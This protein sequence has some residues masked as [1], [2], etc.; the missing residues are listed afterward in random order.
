MLEL[1]AFA[2]RM[3]AGFGDYCAPDDCSG[4]DGHE[5]LDVR[6]HRLAA[7]VDLDVGNRFAAG[8]RLG[9][10]QLRTR[11]PASHR[12]Q[13]RPGLVVGPSDPTKKGPPM[14]FYSGSE[15]PGRYLVTISR[16]GAVASSWQSTPIEP[17]VTR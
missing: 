4:F 3:V 10:R 8:V 2:F 16:N 9:V 6:C 15:K 7:P 17:K 11:E 12:I 1:G 14:L 13:A 5:L